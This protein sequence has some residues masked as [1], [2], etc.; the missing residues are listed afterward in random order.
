MLDSIGAG[1][2]DSRGFA[3]LG[4]LL[5]DVAVAVTIAAFWKVHRTAALM[6]L[7][8][9]AWILFATVLNYSV[10]SLNS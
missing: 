10:W 3:L 5:L 9:L 2:D 7:P 1:S 4:I 8:Y 6:L